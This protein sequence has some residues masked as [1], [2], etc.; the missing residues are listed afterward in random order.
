MQ[1]MRATE[2]AWTEVMRNHCSRH[3]FDAMG[4]HTTRSIAAKLV[5]AGWKVTIKDINTD[6]EPTDEKRNA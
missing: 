5:G 4:A 6:E 3:L 2:Y 1:E